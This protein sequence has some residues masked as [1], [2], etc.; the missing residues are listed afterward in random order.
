MTIFMEKLQVFF[1]NIDIFFN[2]IFF[3]AQ[4]G[5]SDA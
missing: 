1:L 2:L 4:S 3:F 5:S